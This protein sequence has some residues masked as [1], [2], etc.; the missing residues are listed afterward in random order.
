MK[1]ESR[2]HHY[3]S[4]FYLKG[5]GK[6]GSK[7]PPIVVLDLNDKKHFTTTSN[8]LANIR[9]F[10]RISLPNLKADAVETALSDKRLKTFFS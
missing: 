9:D 1:S 4:Q 10:N 2:K 8:N 7:N 6:T 3:I 5:F